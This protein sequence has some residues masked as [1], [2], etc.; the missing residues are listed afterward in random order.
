YRL[1]RSARYGG[2]QRRAEQSRYGRTL[3]RATCRSD[4]EAARFECADVH[5]CVNDA[6]EPNSALIDRQRFRGISIAIQIKSIWPQVGIA[7]GIDCRAARQKRYRLR[8]AAVI[9]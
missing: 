4:C 8:R 9:C 2:D 5:R 6:S 7:A 3:T 1:A